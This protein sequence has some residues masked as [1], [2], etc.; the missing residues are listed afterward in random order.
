MNAPTFARFGTGHGIVA[1]A[2][3]AAIE[4]STLTPLFEDFDAQAS[5][6]LEQLDIVLRDAGAGRGDLL[7]VECFLAE[8]RWFGAWNTHYA[9]HFGTTPPA[10]TT[11]VCGLPVDGLLIEVQAIA[12]I[13][14]SHRRNSAP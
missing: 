8:R 9:D 10:R 12:A 14:P 3:I 4:P 5:W 13:S 1:T 11:L 2:G 7:R 6:V